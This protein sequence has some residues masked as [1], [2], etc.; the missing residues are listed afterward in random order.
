M[1]KSDLWNLLKSFSEAENRAFARYL[2][3][4]YFSVRS[5]SRLLFKALQRHGPDKKAV[6]RTVFPQFEAYNDHRLR[7]AMSFL[8]RNALDFAALEAVRAE[9][10]DTNLALSAWLRRRGLT[11]VS[12]S[13]IRTARRAVHEHPHRDLD[14]LDA[15]YRLALAEYQN[16]EAQL[17]MVQ[18]F[19]DTLDRTFLTRKLWQACSMASYQTSTSSAFDYGLLDDVMRFLDRRG[20]PDE[21]A[22]NVYYHYLRALKRPD[23]PALFLRF[24]ALVQENSGRFSDD[25][26]RDLYRMAVN[27]CIRQNNA[28]NTAYREEQLE[29]YRLGLDRCLFL[30]DGFL[31]R[32]TYQNIVTTGLLVHRYDWVEQ[33]IHQFRDQLE[34]EHRDGLYAFN[35]ARLAYHRNQYDD[36]LRHLRHADFRDVMLSLAAKALQVKLYYEMDAF[37]LL[38]SHLQALQTFIVRKKALG[39]HRRN[40]QH[41]I[42]LVR[43]LLELP[44]GDRAQRTLLRE[45]IIGTR[46]LA[47]KDWLL[48]RLR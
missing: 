27:F 31:P 25:T 8:Y 10:V 35:L 40:Y 1:D 9:A 28:G 15:E 24:K 48:G 36:A 23:D 37:D 13:A 30:S 21:P 19:S 38:E 14:Q 32:Y 11:R 20:L 12:D 45:Q 41:F 26:L 39:Y 47:E 6:F 44:P 18:A 16:T 34:P 29:W 3:S 42:R 33:F 7:M 43:R 22:L 2:E 4:P 5:E 46:E 17:P